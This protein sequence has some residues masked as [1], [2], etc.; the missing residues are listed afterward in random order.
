MSIVTK[1]VCAPM[2]AEAT[3]AS[4]PACPPP[5]TITSYFN[6]IILYSAYFPAKLRISERN[7]KEKRIFLLLLFRTKVNSVKP[8]LRISERNAKEKTKFLI[9][10]LNGGLENSFS[11]APARISTDVKITKNFVKNAHHFHKLFTFAA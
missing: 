7:A 5:I 9:S 2:R 1:H 11:L 3:A 6:V 4:Q 8:K 10:F